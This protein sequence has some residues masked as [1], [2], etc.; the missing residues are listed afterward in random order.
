MSP[1]I[2]IQSLKSQLIGELQRRLNLAAAEADTIIGSW[3]GLSRVSG[4]RADHAAAL[5]ARLTPA[6]RDLARFCQ[7]AATQ[8]DDMEADPFGRNA[9]SNPSPKRVCPNPLAR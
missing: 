2:A 6:L 1:E 5:M 7:S 3:D 9:S 4:Q 8:I